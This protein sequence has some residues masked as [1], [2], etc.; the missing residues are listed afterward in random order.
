MKYIN[1]P[2]VN[3]F[4]KW[5]QSCIESGQVGLEVNRD[6]YLR[7]VPKLIDWEVPQKYLK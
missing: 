1:D 7:I 2:K 5:Y 4:I 3:D 6:Y